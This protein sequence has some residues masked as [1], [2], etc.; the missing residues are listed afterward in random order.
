MATG[1]L[2]ATGWRLRPPATPEPHLGLTWGLP[3]SSEAFTVQLEI[4]RQTRR[5]PEALY[6]LFT[7]GGL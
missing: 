1:T 4:A 5:S 2:S 6:S 3:C 7:R